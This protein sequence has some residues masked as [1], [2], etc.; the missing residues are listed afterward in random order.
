[1]LSNIIKKLRIVGF[2][3][4]SDFYKLNQ[5]LKLE[6]SI[7]FDVF[8]IQSLFKKENSLAKISLK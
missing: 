8:D 4:Q 6:N 2:S 1:M 3:L 7:K 5:M